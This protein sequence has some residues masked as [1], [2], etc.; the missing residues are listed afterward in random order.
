MSQ[1][2]KLR[3]TLFKFKPITLALRLVYVACV[4]V[5]HL[6]R[7]TS[8]LQSSRHLQ[9]QSTTSEWLSQREVA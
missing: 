1:T 6:Y 7:P 4:Y 5:V 9:E 2:R 3:N 8:N